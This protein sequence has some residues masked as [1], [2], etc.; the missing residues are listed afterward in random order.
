MHKLAAVLVAFFLVGCVS[1]RA[2][3]HATLDAATSVVVSVEFAVE[4]GE[5]PARTHCSGVVIDVG[6]ILTNS[7]CTS[8]DA[9]RP[10]TVRFKDGTHS[11]GHLLRRAEGY[12]AALLVVDPRATRH[13]ARVSST[14]P[15]LGAAVFAVG[16]PYALGWTVTL[17]AVSH[18]H[19]VF[20]ADEDS[21]IADRTWIQIDAAVNPGN[22][23]G[24][25]FN[26]RGE[27]I[28]VPTMK[29]AGGDNLAFALPVADMLS[30]LG[31][32]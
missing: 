29:R 31:V 11:H 13:V 4:P 20:S 30:K 17:G 28:G 24:G 15:V 18:Q 3:S 1:Q 27:L 8:I 23:G 22:S 6:L 19:R 26:V 21:E 25:L 7:H 10:Y 2:P 16:H 5:K 12:D 14:L 32:K 9:K